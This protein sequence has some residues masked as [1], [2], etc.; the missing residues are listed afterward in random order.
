MSPFNRTKIDSRRDL[1]AIVDASDRSALY[2]A[3]YNGELLKLDEEGRFSSRQVALAGAVHQVSP[4]K[5]KAAAFIN[6]RFYVLGWQE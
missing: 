4:D 5:R 1:N 3:T 2:L 6:G